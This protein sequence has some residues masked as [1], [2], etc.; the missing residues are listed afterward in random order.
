[1]LA[2]INFWL[3][4]GALLSEC[5]DRLPSSTESIRQS[6]CSCRGG[7]PQESEEDLDSLLGEV[8]A[9]VRGPPR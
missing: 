9:E 4:R 2:K 1:M 8:E 5:A 7:S 3:W 6:P